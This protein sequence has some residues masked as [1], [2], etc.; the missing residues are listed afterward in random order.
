MFGK[1]SLSHLNKL[2]VAVTQQK[3]TE[4]PF[5]S[6]LLLNK[7]QGDYLCV[8]CGNKLFGSSEKFDSGSGWPSFFRAVDKSV[9]FE[10]DFSYGIERV[11]VLCDECDSHLGHYFNDG[12]KQSRFCINGC[13]LNFVDK[14]ND[15]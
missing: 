14:K 4:S 11:E 8:V 1:Y 10:N 9:K 15:S 6:D 2:Q 5:S 13:C 7:A 3:M 12:P